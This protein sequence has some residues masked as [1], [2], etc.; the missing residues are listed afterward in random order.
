MLFGLL[1][2]TLY[3]LLFIYGVHLTKAGN[4]ALLLSSSTVFVALLS[5]LAGHETFSPRVALGIVLSLSGVALVITEKSQVAISREGLFGDFLILCS[6]ICWASYT[7][8]GRPLLKR[9][10][11]M[12]FS[13]L[14]FGFGAV[15]FFLLSLPALAAQDWSAVR[16][17]SY[18]ELAFSLVFALAV[19]YSLWF[20]GV[21]RLGST[22][23]SIYGNLVPFFGVT[24]A[25]LFLGEPLTLQQVSGGAL[26]VV[27]ALLTRSGTRLRET[28]R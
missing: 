18:L 20:Y 23:T 9:Y 4:V 6:A 13:T 17:I 15:G 8:Y 1:G 16:P 10:S 24:S 22:R 26:I 5:R 7:V 19:A 25:W 14:T 21:S 3:Q 12:S 11:T 2:N 27:G 28:A